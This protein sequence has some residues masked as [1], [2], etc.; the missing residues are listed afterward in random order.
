MSPAHSP[1]DLE[2]IPM[3]SLLPII[4]QVIAGV[5]GGQAVGAALGNAVM[6]Q[7]PKLL[8]GAIGG[9]GGASPLPLPRMRPPP[10]FRPDMAAGDTTS[11]VWPG[12]SSSEGADDRGLPDRA[13]TAWCS[14]LR[15]RM[16][17]L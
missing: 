13:S 15:Q 4:V 2:G 11:E 3:E 10:S 14:M 5:V 7:L 16:W 12:H 17:K 9:V 6:G 8:S 1:D